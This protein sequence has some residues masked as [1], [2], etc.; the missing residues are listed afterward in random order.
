MIVVIWIL[1]L[2]INVVLYTV[3]GETATWS[4]VV[5]HICSDWYGDGGFMYFY[6]TSTVNLMMFLWLLKN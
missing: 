4:L 5:I 2:I 3:V 1:I 6:L